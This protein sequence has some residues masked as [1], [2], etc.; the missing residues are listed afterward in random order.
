M[1]TNQLSQDAKGRGQL[2][3]VNQHF[4]CFELRQ[5]GDQEGSK[6][7]VTRC[8]QKAPLRLVV[9][10]SGKQ[11]LNA[12]RIQVK[13]LQDDYGVAISVDSED[14]GAFLDGSNG[15]VAG[16]GVQDV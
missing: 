16:G 12:S 15:L 3:H 11:P 9:V 5:K 6:P 13:A 7:Y 1:L 14:V 10:Y 8:P 2:G 4:R